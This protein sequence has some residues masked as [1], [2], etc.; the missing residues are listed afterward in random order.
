MLERSL[1][2]VFESNALEYLILAE[3]KDFFPS[4]KS[5][6]VI[7]VTRGH[8]PFG[9]HQESRPLAGPD[10]LSVCMSVRFVFS[11]NQD[12]FELTESP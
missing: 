6:S 11:A 10:F 3:V 2:L 9:Q 12:L 4:Q 1:A 8:A 5:S 7:L